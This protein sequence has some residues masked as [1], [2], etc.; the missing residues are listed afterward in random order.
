MLSARPHP[1]AP[2]APPRPASPQIPFKKGVSIQPRDEVHLCIML[3]MLALCAYIG[4]MIGS[5]L[6]GAF[7][8][9]MCFV[10]VPRS[11]QVG[12]LAEDALSP[13]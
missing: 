1:L 12:R 6:L 2:C 13:V 8:A 9:G 11:H 5:H 7:V 3:L 10:S 4:A